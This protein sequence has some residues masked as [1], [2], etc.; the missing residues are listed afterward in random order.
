[1]QVAKLMCRSPRTCQPTDMLDCAVQLMWDHDVGF[2]PVVDDSGMLVGV[3]TDR[4][5]CMAAYMQGQPLHALPVSIAMTTHVVTCR[6]EDTTS[7]ASQLMAKHKIRRI[8]IVD[9]DDHPIGVVS[10][11]DFAVAAARR[12]PVP[13]HEVA[14]TLGAI[15]E[16]RALATV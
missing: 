2:V 9:D 11:N 15:C 16:H 14:R 3:V 12:E 5:A 6:P 4:D 1:M 8:P 7:T 13:E 10:L